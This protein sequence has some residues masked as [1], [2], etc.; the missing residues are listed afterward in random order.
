MNDK[1]LDAIDPCSLAAV[2]GGS[3]WW[4]KSDTAIGGLSGSLIG[5]GTAARVCATKIPS[6][7]AIGIGVGLA[8]FAYAGKH[9]DR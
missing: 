8:T 5:G 9:I 6:C 2:T 1:N 4:M 3:E 7:I